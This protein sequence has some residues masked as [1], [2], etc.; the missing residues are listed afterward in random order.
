M[1]LLST[2]MY[3]IV[4]VFSFIMAY[5]NFR[6][7]LRIRAAG[8]VGKAQIDAKMPNFVKNTIFGII[9]KSSD[10][11]YILPFIFLSAIVIT[12]LELFCTGQVYLPTI[13][14][15][16]S[17]KGFRQ[18]AILYLFPVLRALRPAACGDFYAFLSRNKH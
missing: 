13:I 11:K 17:L 1:L 7:A 12:A 3:F 4:A 16:E 10:I 8:N 5:V 6:D 9:K 18:T 14:Y 2:I 15:L